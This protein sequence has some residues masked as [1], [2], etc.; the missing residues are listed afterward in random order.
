MAA[1]LDE[2][3]SAARRS[4]VRDPYA[5]HPHGARGNVLHFLRRHAEAIEAPK[6]ALRLDPHVNLWIYAV[7]RALFAMGRYEEGEASFKRRLIHMPTSDASRVCLA[8]LHGHNGRVDEARRIWEG[9]DDDASGVC[10][11]AYAAA[12]AVPQRAALGT[13]GRDAMGGPRP[14]RQRGIRVRCGTRMPQ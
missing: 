10:D 14:P 1:Q 8:S 9:V 4:I 11:R 5:A 2:A 3:E 7:G 12:A 6:L 13:A